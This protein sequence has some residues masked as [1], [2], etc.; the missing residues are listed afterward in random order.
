MFLRATVAGALAAGVVYAYYYYSCSMS[1][2]SPAHVCVWDDVYFKMALAAVVV[3]GAVAVWKYKS[4]DK[5]RMNA[6]MAELADFE[7][8]DTRS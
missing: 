3:A 6:S 8:Q 4:E 5:S 1:T 7:L 2:S